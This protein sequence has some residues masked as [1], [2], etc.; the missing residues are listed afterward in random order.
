VTEQ[1][2]SPGQKWTTANDGGLYVVNEVYE[3]LDGGREDYATMFESDGTTHAFTS[4]LW[5]LRRDFRLVED[6][7]AGTPRNPAERTAADKGLTVVLLTPGEA[8]RVA[9]GNSMIAG[10]QDG[11]EVLIRLYRPEEFKTA[12]IAAAAKV[13]EPSGIPREDWP[14][15]SDQQIADLVRP[16]RRQ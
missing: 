8:I 2:V 16:L 10:T 13:F 11:G 1:R 4:P 15:V 9:Q 7:P 14:I 5:I 12:H 6:V 3:N